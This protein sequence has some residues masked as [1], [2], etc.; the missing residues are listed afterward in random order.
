MEVNVRERD[1]LQPV[2]CISPLIISQ[3][4]RSLGDPIILKMDRILL[5]FW[6]IS[7][8]DLFA[9]EPAITTTE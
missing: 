2:H 6:L 5:V 9:T 1:D 4:M 7:D 3:H 8:G